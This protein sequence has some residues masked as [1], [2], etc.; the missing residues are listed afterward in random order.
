[1]RKAYLSYLLIAIVAV[2]SIGAVY[3]AGVI[4][5]FYISK[6]DT[7]GCSAFMFNPDSTEALNVRLFYASLGNVSLIALIFVALIFSFKR[8]ISRYTMVAL[9]SC[10]V[11]SAFLMIQINAGRE[12]G[13]SVLTLCTNHIL[14]DYGKERKGI[15]PPVIIPDLK[16]HQ[17]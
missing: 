8:V 12:A 10:L 2:L 11:F 14:P 7:R 5:F 6:F 16:P 4:D 15:A 3:I 13:M 9:G 17:E 1:M